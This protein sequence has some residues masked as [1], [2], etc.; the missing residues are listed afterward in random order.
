MKIGLPRALAH[1][2]YYPL[3]QKLFE[4]L[5]HEVI[6]SDETEPKMLERGIKVTISEFC[7]PIKVFNAH[8]INLLEKG[9]DFCFVP[10][11][12]SVGKEWFCPKFL[13]LPSAVQFSIPQLA[14]KMLT[15]DVK[16]KK[17][18]DI[19]CFKD[20]LMLCEKLSV[21]KQDMKKAFNKAKKHFEA[22]RTYCRKGHTID[23]ADKLLRGLPLKPQTTEPEMTIGVL[24]YVYNVYDKYVSMD[25]INRLKK[26]NVRVITFEMLDEKITENP[27]NDE[28]KPLFWPFTRKIYNAGRHLVDNKMVD[29]IIHVTAFA[30]GPD[31]VI[32]KMFESDFEGSGISFMTIRMDEHSGESHVQTRIEAFCDMLSRKVSR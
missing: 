17:Y 30:C 14:D 31:S 11:L 28:N 7:I 9:V 10:R 24:G 26:A 4:E 19:G 25:I 32:G 15:C 5:G 18:D 6:L 8:V 22:F 20:Y 23:E 13:G 3:W 27:K 2:Y 29:G 12:I 21:T 16:G 1:Y